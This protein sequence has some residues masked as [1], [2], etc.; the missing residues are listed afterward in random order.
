MNSE[1]KTP[2]ANWER[3]AGV[4]EQCLNATYPQND[5]L[6]NSVPAFLAEL[7]ARLSASYFGAE[8]KFLGE[9]WDIFLEKNQQKVENKNRKNFIYNELFSGQTRQANP[10]TNRR[11]A[12]PVEAAVETIRRLRDLRLIESVL[13]SKT[14]AALL[15]GSASYGRFLNVRGGNDSSDLD[16]LLVVDSF[17]KFPQLIE[18]IGSIKTELGSTLAVTSS[19]DKTA[20]R[21]KEFLKFKT[22]QTD[23]VIF[24]AK[25]DLWEKD[26]SLL[27]GCNTSSNYHLSIHII[28]RNDLGKLLHENSPMISSQIIGNTKEIIDYRDTVP[29]KGDK[30]RSFSGKGN[31][32]ASDTYLHESSYVRK[33]KLFLIKD[34]HYFPGMFQNLILPAF[35]IRW[36]DNDCRRLIDSFRWKMIDRLRHEQRTHPSKALKLS[37][38]HTRSDVFAPHV[39]RA[40]DASTILG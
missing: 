38:A 22:G 30:Q 32:I 8:D 5:Y 27:E 17:D 11:Q 37:Y 6:P 23:S 21:A 10:I 34:G 16:M 19:I 26:D 25:I 40:V 13:S 14:K 35:D 39:A 9:A 24:S 33:T 29:N 31:A 28:S 4:Y 2:H 1:I 7:L 20:K 12:A 36:G 3:V 15:G 18:L